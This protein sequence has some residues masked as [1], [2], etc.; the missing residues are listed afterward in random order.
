MIDYPEMPNRRARRTKELKIQKESVSS[1]NSVACPVVQNCSGLYDDY[2]VVRTAATINEFLDTKRRAIGVQRA[3]VSNG[4]CKYGM[5]HAIQ[6]VLGERESCAIARKIYESGLLICMSVFLE[7]ART[8][9][10]FGKFMR[11]FEPEVGIAITNFSFRFNVVLRRANKLSDIIPRHLSIDKLPKDAFEYWKTRRERVVRAID[12]I[13]FDYV[14]NETSYTDD[15]HARCAVSVL[16]SSGPIGRLC[17]VAE[18]AICY[19]SDMK[20]LCRCSAECTYVVCTLCHQDF[21]HCPY[22]GM[23]WHFP[24]ITQYSAHI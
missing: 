23:E 17:I 7:C 22:C 9:G 12:C 11:N 20:Q 24:D 3:R 15:H 16:A 4:Q 5:E 14:E 6:V 2:D 8:N 18:C 19:N 10:V 13:D 21:Q 1:P